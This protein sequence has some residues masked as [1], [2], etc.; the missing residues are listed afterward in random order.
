MLSKRLL[1]PTLFPLA[2]Y[3]AGKMREIFGSMS[4][5]YLCGHLHNGAGLVPHMQH[6]H[7]TG[8]AELEL[9][10]WKKNRAFRIMTM[11]H[12]LFSFSDHKWSPSG[13]YVH[14]SNPPE[15]RLTNPSKQVRFRIFE[16]FLELFIL[17][18]RSSSKF[19]PHSSP[20]LFRRPSSLGQCNNRR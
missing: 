15:W 3:K 16:F 8:V 2:M 5:A 9:S 10:D 20:H 12:D 17:A 6:M 7:S 13:I 4:L 14:I 19:N 11:D 18:P 1:I